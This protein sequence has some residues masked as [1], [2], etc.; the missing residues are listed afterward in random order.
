MNTCTDITLLHLELTQIRP[1][2]N[3]EWDTNAL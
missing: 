1:V 2:P 3:Y